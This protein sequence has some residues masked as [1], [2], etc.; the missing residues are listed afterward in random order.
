[1]LQHMILESS[2]SPAS[3]LIIDKVYEIYNQNLL[4]IDINT[5]ADSYRRVYVIYKNRNIHKKLF[6]NTKFS[7]DLNAQIQDLMFRHMY[8]MKQAVQ[9]VNL[10]RERRWHEKLIQD[11]SNKS[12]MTPP[13]Y[14]QIKLE[15]AEIKGSKAWKLLK[16]YR[17][18]FDKIRG[19]K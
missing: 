15:L 17:K 18:A 2:V 11:L 3:S 1:M 4:N 13:D 8:E 12:P 9:S 6:E 7:D 19:F 14:E 10:N 5:S 16:I